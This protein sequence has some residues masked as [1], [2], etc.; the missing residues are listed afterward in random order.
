M[1]TYV[2]AKRATEY[3]FYVSLVSQANTKLVQTNPTLA[4]GDFQVSKDGG[5]LANLTTLPTVTPA[6]GPLVKITLSATE[7][8]ADNVTVVCRDAAGAQWC[9]LVINIQTTARQIDDLAYPATSGRSMVVDAAGLVDA[10]TVKVGPTGSGTAQTAGDIMADTNDIQTRLPAALVSGRM[11][12][13][14]GAVATGAITA[15]AIADAAIDAATFAAGAIDAAAIAT[16]AIGSAEMA[17]SA[18]DEIVNAVWDELTA[19]AR[20]AGSYGQLVKD[21][22]N[23][24]IGSRATQTSVDNVQADTDNMQT[25][26]PAALV[27]GRMDSS[28][29]AMANDVITAAA[30]AQDASE[31]IIKAVSGTADAGSST[32]TIVDAER[33]EADTDYWAGSLVLMTGGPNVGQARRI[34]AFNATTDTITVANAFTQAVAA[35][36]TYIILRTAALEAPG[37]GATDWTSAEKNQIR[38]AL[39]VDGAKTAATGGQLQVI[40]DYIDTE[41]AAIKTKTDQ[42]AFTNVN[43]VDAAVLTASDF[44]QAAADKTW[45]SATRTLTS[46]GASLVQE[47]WDRAT[48]ALTTV[49]SIGKLIVDNIDV[50]ISSRAPSS[51]A[52]SNA[53]YTSAR[54]AKLDNL[55]A[56]VTTRATPTQVRTEVQG[57]LEEAIPEQA[58]GA[59]SATPT[60][61]QA[62]MYLFMSWRN[63]SQSTSTERRI[64]NDAG[65]VIAKSTMSDDGVTF[66][67][68]KLVSG[69]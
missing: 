44:A 22:I 47:V 34:S 31:E 18:V 13:S 38:D 57:E 48:S 59:P 40:D 12:S 9:D 63:A 56:A 67:Q 32:T 26:L 58:Q 16:D 5:A 45:S 52:V 24:T 49:G 68:G 33:T 10:N 65:A 2:P 46:L 11:D 27:S 21:D 66:D 15:A 51:T 6:S 61:K 23:A 7:M 14:V 25:R 28:V 42:L 55:D 3:I 43:K 41:V 62:L 50:T 30:L 64:K 1:A 20:T 39:G 35:G 29:G 17:A 60:V 69:P 36:N 19:E 37:A 4:S 53:D 54:A 8:T